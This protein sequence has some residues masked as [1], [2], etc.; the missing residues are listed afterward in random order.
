M[1]ADRT[2]VAAL[3]TVSVPSPAPLLLLAANVALPA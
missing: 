2:V 1:R 3:F